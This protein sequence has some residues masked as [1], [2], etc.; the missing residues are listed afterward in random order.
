MKKQKSLELDQW[1]SN[2]VFRVAKRSGLSQNQIMSMRWVL[3]LKC[4]GDSVKPKARLVVKGFTDPDL[5]NMRV[6]APTFV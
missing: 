4:D 3:T 2:S 1:V 5:I 6:E